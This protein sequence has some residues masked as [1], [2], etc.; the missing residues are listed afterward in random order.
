MVISFVSLWIDAIPDTRFFHTSIRIEFHENENIFDY[1]FSYNNE[2]LEFGP[3]NRNPDKELYLGE[4]SKTLKE[5]VSKAEKLN[6][7]TFR[8]YDPCD[9][10]C[11]H[12]SNELSVWLCGQKIPIEYLAQGAVG[13]LAM[14]TATA[15]SCTMFGPFGV[16]AFPVLKGLSRYLPNS[17]STSGS[18]SSSRP[19]SSL[20]V[21]PKT[22]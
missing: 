5:V 2:G 8:D 17:G 18:G 9:R 13:N 3:V 11:N 21:K 14:L 22:P 10:N 19:S 20:S 7:T 1:Y 16:I 15:V 4:S 6:A 12:F